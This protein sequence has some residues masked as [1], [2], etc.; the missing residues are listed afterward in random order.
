VIDARRVI[1][2]AMAAATVDE[3]IVLVTDSSDA[4]LRWANDTMTTN[5]VSTGR[6][7]T[8]ISIV[9]DGDTA[10]VGS[11]ETSEV[12]PSAIP[13]VVAASEAAARGARRP[14]TP[15]RF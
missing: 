4:S 6:S 1:D 7:T 3:T 9:R 8:V 15:H 10:H 5:G 13:A 14:G 12:D 2:D 11:V